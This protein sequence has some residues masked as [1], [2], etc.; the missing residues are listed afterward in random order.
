MSL[1]ELQHAARLWANLDHDPTTRT[2]LVGAL[3]D[4]AQ[5]AHMMGSP[6]TFGTAG[7][8]GPVMAG[9]SGM[10]RRTVRRATQGVV[11][12][13]ATLDESTR[14]GGVVVGCDARHGSRDFYDEVIRVLAHHNIE[15]VALPPRLPTPLVPFTVRHF[16]AAAGIMITASHN[17]APDNGYKLYVTDGAQVNSPVD[18][19]IEKVMNSAAELGDLPEVEIDDTRG[20]LAQM[21][22]V[23][24]QIS[25]WRLP[26]RSPLRI[27]Y[28]PVCG[29]GGQ[30]ATETLTGVG[31]PVIHCVTSQMVPD[32][33]FGGLPFPNPEEAGVL[34]AAVALASDIK[35]DIVIANDPDADRLAVALVDNGSWRILSGDEIGWLL[36]SAILPQCGPDDVVATSI[37][38][39][40]LLLRMAAAA[41]V[42]ARQ[43]LTGFKWI[44]RGATDNERLAF[45]YEEALGY[46]VD[47]TVA[48]KDGISAALA[49]C[50][51]ADQLRCEG[52]SLIDVLANLRR[53]FGDVALTQVSLRANDAADLHRWRQRLADLIVSPPTTWGDCLIS[54]VSDLNEG[55]QG[56]AP[57]TG[58]MLRFGD[59]GRVT[60][61]PSGTEPKM[62]AYIEIVRQSAS[63]DTLERVATA[64]REWFV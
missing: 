52:R 24:H 22:Y 42:T 45:G 48:D 19:F 57:T 56:L 20:R 7:L 3:D 18:S 39:S 40:E 30:T 15:I 59:I 9:P 29:V 16:G 23:E 64:T 10:N 49:I 54:E 51:Y 13:L 21:L 1:D 61:R 25:R 33:N 60:I 14:A 37:V 35:A 5:L 26:K 44:A 41:G 50:S 28:T 63:D 32:P 53:D 34:D 2:Q 62:K 27:V 8:R 46:A 6:L 31:F 12:W 36:A 17:P 11:A 4:E 38:S 58:V 43:T 47:P 55:Y